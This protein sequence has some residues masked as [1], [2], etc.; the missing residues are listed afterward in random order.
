MLCKACNVALG[1]LGDDA[2]SIRRVLDYLT[3]PR[4]EEAV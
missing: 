1:V 4:L 3:V 2:E